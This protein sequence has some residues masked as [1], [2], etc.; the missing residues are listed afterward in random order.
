MA[1]LLTKVYQITSQVFLVSEWLLLSCLKFA[2]YAK[3]LS[4]GVYDFQV[5][6]ALLGLTASP[7][8]ASSRSANTPKI[9]EIWWWIR[10]RKDS[11]KGFIKI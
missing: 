6:L 3:K 1:P 7:S 2:I 9:F 8:K 4:S 10:I 11:N 5:R